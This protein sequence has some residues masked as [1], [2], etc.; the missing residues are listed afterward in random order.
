MT[1]KFHQLNGGV[2]D[3]FVQIFLLRDFTTNGGFVSSHTIVFKI[4][5]GEQNIFYYS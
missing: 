5:Y 3:F 1:T 4:I 2:F